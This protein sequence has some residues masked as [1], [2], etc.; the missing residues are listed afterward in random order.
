MFLIIATYRWICHPSICC[1]NKKH[2]IYFASQPSPMI[3]S[4][5]ALGYLKKIIFIFCYCNMCVPQQFDDNIFLFI[6]IYIYIYQNQ[7]IAVKSQIDNWFSLT[8]VIPIIMDGI[9]SNVSLCNI[10]IGINDYK[11]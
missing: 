11:L 2:K 1:N 4:G 9:Y 7:N 3:N 6:Y 5:I 10:Y 8:P